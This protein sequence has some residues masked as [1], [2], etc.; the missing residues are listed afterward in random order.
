MSRTKWKEN[1][2]FNEKNIQKKLT[3]NGLQM[4]IQILDIKID[5]NTNYLFTD[6]Y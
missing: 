4:A 5:G 1:K 2:E 3:L 6:S